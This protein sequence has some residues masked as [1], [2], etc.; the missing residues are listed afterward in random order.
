MKYFTRIALV[1]FFAM[2]LASYA[3]VEVEKIKSPNDL[4]LADITEIIK[5]ISSIASNDSIKVYVT[6]EP[7]NPACV[8][9][10]TLTISGSV[11]AGYIATLENF[12]ES[13]PKSNI[14]CEKYVV[15]N[16]RSYRLKE[17]LTNV[18]DISKIRTYVGELIQE[19]EVDLR[20]GL[21]KDTFELAQTIV[22]SDR[23]EAY[24][25]ISALF[26]SSIAVEEH[27]EYLDEKAEVQTS[28]IFYEAFDLF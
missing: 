25:A 19:N 20:D 1:S 11:E 13:D 24:G 27:I 8:D 16:K 7:T 22:I 10:A 18:G 26:A 28:V 21:S 3:Q 15:P 14:S 4:P 6:H 9:F 12:V 23:R 17:D 5:P 2:T